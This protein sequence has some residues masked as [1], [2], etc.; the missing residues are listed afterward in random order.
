MKTLYTQHTSLPAKYLKLK[1]LEFLK[2]DCAN[3]DLT[4]EF[5]TLNNSPIQQAYL[6]AEQNLV[7]AGTPIIDYMFKNCDIHMKVNDGDI[8]YQGDVI[9]SICGKAHLLLSNERVL[10]NLVQ[11]LSGIASLTKEYINVLNNKEIKIL[12]TRK[13]TPGIRLFEKYAVNIGGGYNHRMDLFD[14]AMFKDNHLII[15]KD[16]HQTL[17]L[18]TKKHPDKKIQIEVDTF[19]QLET[20]I[21][22]L[23]I[24]IDAILLDNM[25][26]TE[27]TR[28]IDLIRNKLPQCFIESSGGINLQTIA[29]YRTID[30]DGISIG[31][32]THQAVSKNIKFEFK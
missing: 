32:L 12:D 6:I 21:Q 11:R 30:I 31:A 4:T 19:K 28:C 16:I 23:N 25:P 15:L 5:S 9:G 18:F 8:C 20:I 24:N 1:I 26:I 17:N 29:K 10:L 27:T 14:G 7:F 13:T 22:S 2:E 3:H